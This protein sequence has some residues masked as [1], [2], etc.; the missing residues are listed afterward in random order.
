MR[1]LPLPSRALLLLL[2]LLLPAALAGTGSGNATAPAALYRLLDQWEYNAAA[3]VPAWTVTDTSLRH[4]KPSATSAHP[5]TIATVQVPLPTGAVCH[6]LIVDV[7]LVRRFASGASARTPT[8]ATFYLWPAGATPALDTAFDARDAI[9][10]HAPSPD[11]NWSSATNGRHYAAGNYEA[12]VH[13][14]TLVTNGTGWQGND[15]YPT[16]LGLTIDLAHAVNRTD[17][18]RNEIR[19]ATVN[20]TAVAG[21]RRTNSASYRFID[22]DSGFF[23]THPVL[24][25]WSPAAV[26]EPTVLE[27]L[28]A[29]S[30]PHASDTRQ[31]AVAVYANCSFPDAERP[32]PA[33]FLPVA[34]S[35]DLP[36]A[37]A[38]YGDYVSGYVP[39]PPVPP[40]TPTA[41][42]SNNSES[43]T[44]TS[45]PVV[46]LTHEGLHV[47]LWAIIVGSVVI[48]ALLVTVLIYSVACIYRRCEK[49]AT[50][51]RF[52]TTSRQR[53]ERRASRS[54]MTE[55]TY[56]SDP[57]VGL[58]ATSGGGVWARRSFD[59]DD[60]DDDDDAR[61][62][63]TGVGSG[64]DG[65]IA[66]WWRRTSTLLGIGRG[67]AGEQAFEMRELDTG[68]IVDEDDDADVDAAAG[69]T[70]PRHGGYYRDDGT[71]LFG[72]DAESSY[73]EE[74]APTLRMSSTERARG[75]SA[76]RF[77]YET[78]TE[79]AKEDTGVGMTVVPLDDTPQ[80]KK[81]RKALKKVEHVVKKEERR[82]SRSRSHSRQSSMEG[83]LPK[84]DAPAHR[85]SRS[86]S[87]TAS[88]L[89]NLVRRKRKS[90]TSGGGGDGSASEKS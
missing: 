69:A 81:L 27:F 30:A 67:G 16:T 47:P 88:T 80:S 52:R 62:R 43:N 57:E 71:G 51:R 3:S 63:R 72:S 78:E 77:M 64:G 23:R 73:G 60:D 2:L 12:R 87:G 13:R 45:T 37:D 50:Y 25:R 65:L 56:D 86:L 89:V 7:P 20:A 34:S 46:V 9:V 44:T 11:G 85:R 14:F 79:S 49:Q 33:D 38:L 66:G 48:G 26:A 41:S 8:N 61:R 35:P 15:T 55:E 59:N 82:R 70:P 84:A 1:H 5:A 76:Q 17:Y 90:S 10:L 54:E 18:S 4:I 6:H 24:G 75:R 42:A 19:W 74:T 39:A 36:A 68:L 83:A 28:A 22:R 21:W 29:G 53:R 31:L 58:S 40:P 32:P